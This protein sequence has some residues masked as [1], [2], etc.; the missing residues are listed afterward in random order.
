M[1]ICSVIQETALSLTLSVTLLQM[2]HFLILNQSKVFSAPFMMSLHIWKLR[3]IPFSVPVAKILLW[4]L[5]YMT[6]LQSVR[7]RNPTHLT[8]CHPRL[9]R[10]MDTVCQ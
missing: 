7:S 8:A 3:Q 2:S 6:R 4:M 10:N 5:L 9:C 1:R